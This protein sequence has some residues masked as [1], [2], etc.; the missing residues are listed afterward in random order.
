MF[1][2]LLESILPAREKECCYI[3]LFHL[4]LIIGTIEEAKSLQK[5]PIGLNFLRYASCLKAALL[6]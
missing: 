4:F 6:I 1:N 3:K 5:K 2:D